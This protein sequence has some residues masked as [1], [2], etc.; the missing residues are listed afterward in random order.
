MSSSKSSSSSSEAVAPPYPDRLQD[1]A[2]R[3]EIILGTGNVSVR[4]CLSLAYHSVVRL[5]EPAGSD[6]QV[7][8][9]GVP[10]AQ[11]EIVVID[12]TTSVRLTEI[13]PLPGVSTAP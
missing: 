8:V 9:N 5:T 11:C 10:I 1:V 13:L 7:R 6:L 12:D 4:D 2:C 3:V